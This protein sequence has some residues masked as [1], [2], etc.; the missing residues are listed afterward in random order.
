MFRLPEKVRGAKF[1]IHRVVSNYHGFRWP[2]KEIDPNAAEQLSLCLCHKGIAGPD[3]HMNR[4]DRFRPNGH[5]ADRLN[6]TQN[7]NFMRPPKMHRRDDRWVWAPFER[8][9]AGDDAWNPSNTRRGH[10]HMRRRHH[11]EFSARDVTSHRLDRN[12]FMPEDNTRK[13]FDLNIEHTVALRLCKIA[14]LFL[15]KFNIGNFFGTEFT[16]QCLNFP[17]SQAKFFRTI[18]VK[19]L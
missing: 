7:I 3:E 10:R 11:R 14:H 5:R 17:K 18:S 6:A 4:F 13:C 9:R 8:G 1:P 2:R 12:I 16:D 15:S 19:F